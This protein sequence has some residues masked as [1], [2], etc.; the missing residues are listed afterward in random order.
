MMSG[1]DFDDWYPRTRPGLLAALSSWCGDPS[2]ASDAIDEAFARAV[3]RW[4]KVSTATSP[5]G[6]VWRTATNVVRRRMRRRAMEAR[7]GR[8][9]RSSTELELRDPDLVAALHQ[10][11]ERQ[12]TAVVLHHVA[13]RPV[14]EI[15]EMLGIT[16]GTVTATLHQARTRLAQLLD[17]PAAS[18]PTTRID[19]AV[20]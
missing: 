1:V 19:G 2:V 6:W 15:A 12:R 3:E 13:D 14:T 11:T 4:S 10:L 5:E 8:R 20:P 18:E 17:R 16:P 9:E 7:L